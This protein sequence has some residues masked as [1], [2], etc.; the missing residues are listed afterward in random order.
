MR[1]LLVFLS[2][3]LCLAGGLFASNRFTL[4]GLDG[5]TLSSQEL[6]QQRALIV[7]WSPQSEDCRNIA[8]S[9]NRI[10][11]SWGQHLRV[12]SVVVNSDVEAVR[13]FLTGKRLDVPV[14]LDT[15]GT[16]SRFYGISA[17]V[18]VLL[19]VDSGKV[20]T[21]LLLLQE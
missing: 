12:V 9:L 6:D 11:S 2:I 7:V 8:S 15:D 18:P 19:G 20:R 1:K 17:A 3:A 13:N 16:F 10:S 5:G 4:P 14:Y 21:G